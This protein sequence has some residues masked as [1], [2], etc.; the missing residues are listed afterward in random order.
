MRYRLYCIKLIPA[1]PLSFVTCGMVELCC[2]LFFYAV[3][4]YCLR[5][6]VSVGSCYLFFACS[7]RILLATHQFL[8]DGSCSSFFLIFSFDY[9]V[10]ASSG[11]DIF[12]C[13]CWLLPFSV[14][15]FPFLLAVMCVSVSSRFCFLLYV[16]AASG[17]CWLLLPVQYLLTVSRTSRFLPPTTSTR[18]TSHVWKDTVSQRDTI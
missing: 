7:F 6:L 8:L 2:F 12:R 1:L 9:L 4:R 16:L 15:Y 13:F 17:F 5:Y 14:D 18:T 3:H 10:L 11:T